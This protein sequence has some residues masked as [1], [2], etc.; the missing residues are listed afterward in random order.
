MPV[1]VAAAS[2]SLRLSGALRVPGDKSISHRSVILGSLAEG[3]TSVRNF[4][5]GEDCLA[6]IAAFHAM[7]VPIEVSGTDVRIQGVGLAGLAEPPH[8]LD[9]GNSGTGMRLLAGVLA[10]QDFFSVLTGDASLSRRPMLRV[11]EPLRRMG[12]GIQGRQ[13]GKLPPLAI[14]GGRLKALEYTSPVASAQVKSCLLLAGLFAQGCT[15]LREPSLSRDHSERMLAAF[16][17]DLESDGTS[18]RLWPGK[19]LHAQTVEVPGDLS[20]AAFFLV[21][22]SIVPES[23]ILLENVGVNPTRTGILEIL[24]AMGA[25]IAQ[26]NPRQCTGEPVADLR[27]SAAPLRGV[28]LD[29]GVVVK[30][31][32]EIPIACI[33]AACAEGTTRIR[34]AEELRHKESDRLAVMAAVL[35]RLGV[36]ITEYPDGLEIEG[37]RRFLGGD[38][39][40]HHDHR[41]AMSLLVAGLVASER[42]S[43]HGTACVATSF[44]SFFADLRSL[45]A[46]IEWEEPACETG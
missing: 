1:E 2:R 37:G 26:L 31:I 12:A 19:T 17:A 7:G 39:D 14:R 20:S 29:G 38:F 28:Q 40:S 11:V 33:A 32:D 41:V 13:G 35:A 24:S 46:A 42:I 36:K 4:L 43:V 34:G 25:R 30:A 18:V 15:I 6:T 22:G 21:A 3:T 45:G 23:E 44:P 5:R 8:V 16:G 10:G 27:V 9:M